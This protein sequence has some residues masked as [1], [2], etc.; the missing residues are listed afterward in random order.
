MPL[1]K[2]STI[3]TAR[4]VPVIVPTPPKMETPPSSTMVMMSSSKP[5]A[6]SPRTAPTR[7]A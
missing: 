7:A 1:R 6:T 2:E 3:S 4:S 5:S